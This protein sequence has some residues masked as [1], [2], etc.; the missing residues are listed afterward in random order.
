MSRAMPSGVAGREH[1]GH[2]KPADLELVAVPD[3]P[4]ETIDAVVA[5]EHRK[6]QVREELYKLCISA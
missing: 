1:A 5:A 3:L 2:V 6:V 4:G